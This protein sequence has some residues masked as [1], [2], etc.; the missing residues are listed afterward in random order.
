[1]YVTRISHYMMLYITFG[2]ICGFP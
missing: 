1:M 2:I